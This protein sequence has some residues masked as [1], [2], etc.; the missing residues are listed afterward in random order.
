MRNLLVFGAMLLA[1]AALVSTSAKP[2]QAMTNAYFV[3][4]ITHVSTS[5]IKVKNSG[6]QELSFLI[7]PKFKNIWSEDGKTTYQMSFLK[8]GTKVKVTYDQS[9]LGARHADK[10]VVLKS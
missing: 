3:G 10:I 1:A 6:G 2:A 5:N 8:P 9:A 7:V 4:H